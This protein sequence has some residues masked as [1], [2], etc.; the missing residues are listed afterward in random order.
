MGNDNKLFQD[1]QKA[2]SSAIEEI[3]ACEPRYGSYAAVYC[4]YAAEVLGHKLVD[5]GYEPTDIW[6]A[7]NAAIHRW[8]AIQ[9]YVVDIW[10]EE[11]DFRLKYWHYTHPGMRRMRMYNWP[12]KLSGIRP[13][14]VDKIFAPEEV[15]VYYAHWWEPKKLWK[16]LR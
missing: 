2:A 12:G 11:G 8:L 7:P 10:E 5:L 16:S 4:G 14:D 3:K 9:D 15:S 1:L 13:S 6:I